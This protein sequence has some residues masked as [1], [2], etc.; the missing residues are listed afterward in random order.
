MESN[1]QVVKKGFEDFMK[2]N[3]SAIVNICTDDVTWGSYENPNVPA[4]G[5][6]KGK[7]G[8]QQF[9][10]ALGENIDFTDFSP[11]EFYEQGDTVFVLGHHAGKVKKTGRT[12]SHDWAMVF[13]IR[14]TKIN[15]FFSFVDTRD[16]AQA[17]QGD[18]EMQ[19][20]EKIPSAA[21]KHDH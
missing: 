7:K 8:V 10:S 19:R 9:F 6:F 17:F 13:K 20:K 3:T 12:F 11:R 16:Q 18:L 2:G 14:D 15:Y 5:P 21:V 1:V 4:A